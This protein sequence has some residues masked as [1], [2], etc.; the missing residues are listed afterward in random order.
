MP[1][2]LPV[3]IGVGSVLQYSKPNFQLSIDIVFV[4]TRRIR[5]T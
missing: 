1:S 2:I 5:K 4:G 3:D